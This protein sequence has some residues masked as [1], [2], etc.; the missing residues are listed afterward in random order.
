MQT[1]IDFITANWSSITVPLAVFIFS[2]IA[3]FWLRKIVLDRLAKWTKKA[4]WT[5]DIALMRTVKAPSFLLCVILSLYLGLAISIAPSSW[6][7]PAGNGL[8]TLF[9]IALTLSLLSLSRS[10]IQYCDR[11]FILTRRA[12]GVAHNVIRIIVL[13]AAALVVLDLWGISTSP[14]LLFLAIII[15]AGVLLFRDAVPNLFASFQIAAS[16]E[17]K[18]GDFIKLEGQ[19]GGYVT[20]I[21]WQSTTLRSL[22]G[23]LVIMPNIQLIR[24]NIIN[25]GHPRK[26]ATEPFYFNTRTHMAELTG[27][28]AANLQELANYLKQAPDTVIYYHTHHFLEEHQYLIPELSNDFAVWVKDSLGNEILSERLANVNPFEFTSLIALRD[29]LVQ[30]IE[31]YLTAVKGEYN[32]TARREFHFMKSVSVILPTSYTAHDLR[33]FVEALRNI[34]PRSLYFHI[35]ESR[36]RLGNEANDFSLWLEKYM[37]E[38]E[39]GKEVAK[40]DPYTYNLEGLRSLLVQVIEKQIK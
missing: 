11:K 36:L 35:F 24:R 27:L 4:V 40:I 7:G 5:E 32:V 17:I 28:R 20:G 25:Y 6:K 9:I 31:E 34:S 8:W 14:L 23:G 29:E 39:L 26:T 33:E 15:L 21:N 22:D 37:G 3:L 13:V 38:I 30:I 18:A 12:V 1:A 19:E 16:Q 2:L 10:F